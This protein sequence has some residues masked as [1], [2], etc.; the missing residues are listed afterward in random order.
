MQTQS[1]SN[2]LAVVYTDGL[3]ADKLLAGCGYALRAAGLAVAGI[4]QFNSFERDPDKCDMVVEE[5]LSGRVLQL[6]E[7]RGREASGCRLDRTVLTEAAALLLSALDE[8]PDILVVNKFGKVEAEGTGLRDVLAKA[9]ESNVPILVGVPY[10]NLDQWRAFAGDLAEECAADIS[11]VRRW[12]VGHG[13]FP[14]DAADD[15]Q[16]TTSSAAMRAF[17]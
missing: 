2:I 10:R 1:S 14:K 5:L 12:L 4:V 15:D 16:P 11:H 9:A 17:Q 13:L 3:A 8:H 6:S 7:R